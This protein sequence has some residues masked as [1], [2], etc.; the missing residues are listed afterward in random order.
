[1]IGRHCGHAN[2]TT[3][4]ARNS[5][6]ITKNGFN[7]TEK[8]TTYTGEKLSVKTGILLAVV[9]TSVSK[10]EKDPDQTVV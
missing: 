3:L 10:F 5:R 4:A 8:K 9:S 7:I 1:M 6:E 2:L